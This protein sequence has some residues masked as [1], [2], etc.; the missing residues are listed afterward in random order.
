MNNRDNDKGHFRGTWKKLLARYK[1]DSNL[2]SNLEQPT[3]G[4]EELAKGN[5]GGLG[6]YG[7]T[8]RKCVSD[9]T[10]E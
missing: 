7:H 5:Y 8:M 1:I 2:N 10:D 9:V 3:T 4:I 6:G